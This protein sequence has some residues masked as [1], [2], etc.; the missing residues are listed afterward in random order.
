MCVCEGERTVLDRGMSS[1]IPSPDFV[2]IFQQWS[3]QLLAPEKNF[4]AAGRT[5]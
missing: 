2:A 4:L 1:I 3:W 5:S